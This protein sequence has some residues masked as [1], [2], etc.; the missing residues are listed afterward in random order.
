M[1]PWIEDLVSTEMSVLCAIEGLLLAFLYWHKFSFMW[2][3]GHKEE[4]F[5]QMFL[6]GERNVELVR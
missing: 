6:E 2:R 3:K 5:L 1:D 4:H